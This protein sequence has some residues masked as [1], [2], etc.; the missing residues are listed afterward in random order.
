MT[1]QA[2]TQ[3]VESLWQR[4]SKRKTASI[5]KELVLFYMYLVKFAA[6]G[7]SLPPRCV[8]NNDD[9]MSIGI[10]GLSE[11]IERF[12]PY[13]GVKFETYASQRIRGIMLDEIRKVDWLPRSIRD[14]YKKAW[15]SLSEL[16]MDRIDGEQYA[17]AI[18]MTVREFDRIKGYLANSEAV[19][20][21]KSIGDDMTLEDVVSGDSE[22]V[23]QY[24]DDETKEQL[25]EILKQLPERER[26]VMTLYYY[27]EITFKEIGK[28][29]GISESR[30]SQIHS[31][32]LDKVKDLFRKA[33]EL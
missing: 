8:F 33:V 22:V 14:K 12:D 30:V 4:Y 13:R 19:S 32:V 2:K 21:T 16:D 9:L 3:D 15:K 27:E 25:V 28:I 5:K 24:E 10:I 11:A 23:E 1:T 31:E 20:L 17:Q 7:I 18:N 6:R 29:L 26:M